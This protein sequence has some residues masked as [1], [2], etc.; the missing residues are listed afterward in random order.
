MIVL[1][2]DLAQSLDTGA[3][4]SVHSVPVEVFQEPDGV[5]P[6]GHDPGLGL[7]GV[8]AQADRTA[9]ATSPVL[10]DQLVQQMT[11]GVGDFFQRGADRLGD[12]LQP[13]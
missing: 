3:G 2:H 9:V 4:R 6:G 13:G 5:V 8:L 7:G 12:Q 1:H 11:G 10:V